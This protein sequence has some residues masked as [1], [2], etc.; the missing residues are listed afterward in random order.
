[1]G[2]YHAMTEYIPCC[3]QE[4][5]IEARKRAVRRLW[6]KETRTYRVSYEDDGTTEWEIPI[7]SA[8]RTG[9][10]CIQSGCYRRT[11]YRSDQ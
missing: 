6:S 7:I 10:I 8:P 2:D 3:E 1:M 11:G 5:P 9:W 4:V